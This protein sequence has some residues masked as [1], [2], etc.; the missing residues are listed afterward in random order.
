MF[1]GLTAFV[2]EISKF[3]LNLPF[4]VKIAI[5]LAVMVALITGMYFV[6]DQFEISYF[7]SAY[8]WYFFVAMINLLN[9]L[10]IYY[11][12]YSKTGNYNGQKGKPGKKGKHGKSGKSVTCSYCKS[13][14]YIQK[15][16]RAD[17]ICTL[18]AYTP[19]TFTD[20]LTTIKNSIR[21]FD[22]LIENGTI[23]YDQFVNNI[24]LEK[25]GDPSKSDAV[26]KF[27][28]LM[29]PKA[30]TYQLVYYLNKI[31][32]NASRDTYGTFRRPVGVT[33]Y[34][35]LGDCV[36]GGVENFQLNSFLLNGDI[37]YP[38]SYTL[39]VSFKSYN[40]ETEDYD[41]YTIWRPVGQTINQIK[42]VT[43]SSN[44]TVSVNYIPMGDVCM[45]GTSQ[46]QLNSLATISE[47]CLEIISHSYLSLV[48]LYMGD[49]DFSDYSQNDYTKELDYLIENKLSNTVQLFSVWRTPMNTFLTNSNQDNLIVNNSLAYNIYNNLDEALNDYG[50]IKTAAKQYLT[51]YF[52]AINI[53]KTT[54]AAILCR[55]FETEYTR[56]LA[57]YINQA[58]SQIAMAYDVGVL[59][60]DEDMPTTTQPGT[61]LPT[62][63]SIFGSISTT[64]VKL[65]DMM[66]AV[67]DTINAY[68]KYN[69]NL[70]KESVNSKGPYNL[71]AEKHLAPELLKVYNRINTDLITL[72]I[73]IENT[74]TL[75][76]I[77][78]IIFDSGI[79]TRIAVD[80]E[81]VHEGGIL[82]NE[83]QEIVLRICKIL[84]PPESPVYMIKDECLGSFPMDKNRGEIIRQLTEQITLHRKFLDMR[85]EDPD[86]YQKVWSTVRQNEDLL[87]LELG[88]VVGHIKKWQK[89]LMDLDL[90][91]FSTSRL[92]SIYFIYEKTNKFYSTAFSTI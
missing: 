69:L 63:T 7:R 57:Y 25:T 20:S 36:Y 9:L 41:T 85:T 54:V 4:S 49:L 90:E 34:I 88:K 74:S 32:A 82:L 59:N 67:K 31:T 92:E 8:F 71:K 56:E 87:N 47:S 6:R 5:I 58:Q 29:Q 27:N 21:Y 83:V 75:L 72:P 51:Q 33:G 89:K 65:G 13:N 37:M 43:Q 18:S 10:V 76:D 77:V 44:E 22:K 2:N 64:G 60:Y 30:L 46:P 12:Y 26:D 16:R 91:E 35:P 86:K 53:P 45:F 39:L 81:G 42:Q 48:F 79:E 61:P 19:T 17:V 84:M 40:Q 3:S 50:N 1:E 62:A 80:A 14:I 73:Q 23:D 11:F 28:A 52:E 24:V 15:S 55:H 78:N 68:E 38:Q 66:K 70:S